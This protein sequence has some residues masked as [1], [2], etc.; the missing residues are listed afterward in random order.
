M[1]IKEE[2]ETSILSPLKFPRL[3]G[4]SSHDLDSGSGASRE[5]QERGLSLGHDQVLQTSGGL[6]RVNKINTSKLPEKRIHT[7]TKLLPCEPRRQVLSLEP[8]HSWGLL[9]RETTASDPQESWPTPRPTPHR[10]QALLTPGH[11]GQ[12]PTPSTERPRNTPKASG[13][14]SLRR[15]GV[16]YLTAQLYTQ[17][18]GVAIPACPQASLRLCLAASRRKRPAHSWHRAGARQLPRG[19]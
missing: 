10:L 16:S 15:R 13:H 17:P 11:S 18:S 5:P 12:E 3:S 9:S 19:S 1:H 6:A 2:S 14:T 4:N 7:L 8:R